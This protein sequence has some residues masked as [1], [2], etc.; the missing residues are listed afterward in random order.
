M[1]NRTVDGEAVVFRLLKLWVLLDH[2]L[3]LHHILEVPNLLVD[4]AHEGEEVDRSDQE[5]G[6]ENEERRGAVIDRHCGELQ[7]RGGVDDE[8]HQKADEKQETNLRGGVLREVS[9]S[10]L[11]VDLISESHVQEHVDYAGNDA[12]EDQREERERGVL[13]AGGLRSC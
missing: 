6:L 4:H 8:L 5:V 3:V 10:P 2:L 7:Q 12:T 11:G 1:L 9:Q 13:V